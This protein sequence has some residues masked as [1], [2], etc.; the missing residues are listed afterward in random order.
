MSTLHPTP[1]RIR[2]SA[3]VYQCPGETHPIS[4]S[5]HLARLAACY[6]AC[7]ECPLA[8]DVGAGNPNVQDLVATTAHRAPRASL[9]SPLGVRGRYLNELDRATAMR[10]GQAVATLLWEQT[11]LRGVLT[12]EARPRARIGLPERKYR[13]DVVTSTKRGPLIVIGYD[14]RTASPEIL[15]GVAWGLRT[16]GC[17]VVDVGL[18]TRPMWAV[19]VAHLQ[20]A[21]GVYITG[22]GRGLDETGFDLAGPNGLPWWQEDAAASPTGLSL[23]RLEKIQKVPLARPSRQRG[24]LRAFMPW[25][26]Y[27]AGLLKHFHA[28]RPLHVVCGTASRLLP[29]VLEEL[30]SRLPCRLTIVPVPTLSGEAARDEAL[31]RVSDA[32]TQQR[33]D[34]GWV[35]HEDG[36]QADFLCERATVLQPDAIHRLICS[37]M[38]A[39]DAGEMLVLSTP[40][41]EGLAG[42]FS[43]HGGIVRRCDGSAGAVVDCLQ[44][45]EATAA[46]TAE[47]TLWFRD[48]VPVADAIV[49][50]AQTLRALSHDDAPLSLVAACLLNS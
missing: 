41:Y 26:T 2:D 30:F 10:W 3:T 39:E 48:T 13:G 14:E 18:A 6:A 16:M 42:W 29:R 37:R 22:A 45:E 24:S 15:T 7:R 9:L 17:Q 49:T 20:A 40:T 50:L 25:Q 31:S 5:V 4:R 12:E 28:L 38:R 47:G 43:A 44:R 34:L 33:A 36:M 1:L 27:T 23:S 8:Q 21:G 11:P 19:A 35:V 32:V 46:I